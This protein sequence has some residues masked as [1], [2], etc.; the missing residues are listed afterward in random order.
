[1]T[2]YFI[3]HGKTAGNLEKRY[4]GRTN[5][6]LCPLGRSELEK[7]EYPQ[8]R[9][10]VSSPLNRCV[11]TARIIWPDKAPLVCSGLRECD[12]GAFE[13]KNYAELN[14]APEYQKWIDSGGEMAF[15]GGEDKKSFSA[16][17]VLAF[18]ELA[19]SLVDETAFVVHGGTI[20]AILERFVRPKRKF[21][22]YYVENGRGYAVR[23]DGRTMGITGR[24]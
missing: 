16:R 22:D 13:G 24:I 11:E 15:P 17:T 7:I 19:P 6:P 9:A 10:G 18:E 2:L 4:I 23:F 12:F 20:M 3:R 8:A 1:M 5:E 21:Y 14:A